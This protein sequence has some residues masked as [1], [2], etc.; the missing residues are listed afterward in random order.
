MHPDHREAAGHGGA[1]GASQTAGQRESG[2]PHPGVSES[3]ARHHGAWTR[4]G[5]P[6]P[7]APFWRNGPPMDL[8]T[9]CQHAG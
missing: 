8:E 3:S 2:E 4:R 9:D 1:G 6:G 5:E 7:A